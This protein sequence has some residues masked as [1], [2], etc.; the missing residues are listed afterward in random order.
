MFDV[1]ALSNA[2]LRDTRRTAIIDKLLMHG[3]I[4]GKPPK[5]GHDRFGHICQSCRRVGVSLTPSSCHVFA[6]D[7]QTGN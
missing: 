3:T 6:K 4:R 5:A 1:V 2:E 7:G